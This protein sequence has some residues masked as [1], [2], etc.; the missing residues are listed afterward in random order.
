LSRSARLSGED[1][2]ALRARYAGPLGPT[3]AP[4]SFQF[5]C[6]AKMATCQDIIDRALRILG[7]L[8]AGE[9]ASGHDGQAGMRGLQEVVDTLPLLRDG[10]WA[11]TKLTGEG[12]YTAADGQRIRTLGHGGQIVLPADAADLSRVQVVGQGHPQAGL[13]IYAAA[14]GAWARADALAIG[15][16]SPFGAD[17]EAG[18]A[19]LLAISLAEEYGA[20][21]PGSAMARASRAQTSFRSRFYR[22]VVVGCADEVLRTAD[23][24]GDG[25]RVG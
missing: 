23:L 3:A 20:E 7:V 8:A 2:G 24:G 12:A 9:V 4:P 18:L 1:A 25:W 15:D 10:E 14:E 11:E 17:D 6:E 16:E 13:W 19:A 5:H 22:E 21:V